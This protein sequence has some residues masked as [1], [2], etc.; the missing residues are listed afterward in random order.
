MSKRTTPEQKAQA[1]AYMRKRN[2]DPVFR[3]ERNR[4]RR[5]DPAARARD[6]NRFLVYAYGLTREKY[7]LMVASQNG[8]CAICRNPPGKKGLVIDHCH[9]TG[10]VRGLLCHSCNIGLGALGDTAEALHRAIKYLDA[11]HGIS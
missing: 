9:D 10:V 8:L 6:R 4:I 3:A 7:D 5:E 1:A 11:P 2:E